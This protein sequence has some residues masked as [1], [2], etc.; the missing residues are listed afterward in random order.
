MPEEDNEYKLT[1]VVFERAKSI[2][3]SVKQVSAR[4]TLKFKSTY[5]EIAGTGIIQHLLHVYRILSQSFQMCE[6]VIGGN[7]N[8]RTRRHCASQLSLNLQAEG[9]WHRL[10][11]SDCLCQRSKLSYTR[12]EIFHRSGFKNFNILM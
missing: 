11:Q 5:L 10:S 6:R 3:Q 9:I 8:H 12:G 2:R 4:T 7:I 1:A